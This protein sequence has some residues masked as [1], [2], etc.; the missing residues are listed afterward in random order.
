MI[1]VPTALIQRF[2]E[3]AQPNTRREIETLGYI[4]GKYLEKYHALTATVLLVPRQGG[5]RESCWD[6]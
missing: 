2:K 3:L 6:I 4:M 5:T 1:K